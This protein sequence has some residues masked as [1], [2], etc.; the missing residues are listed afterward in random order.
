MQYVHPYTHLEHIYEGVGLDPVRAGV[1]DDLLG[2]HVDHD[3]VA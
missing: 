3:L 2:G 1:V